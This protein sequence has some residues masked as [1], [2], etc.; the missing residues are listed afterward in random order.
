MAELLGIHLGELAA[1]FTFCNLYLHSETAHRQLFG[2]KFSLRT[3]TQPNDFC[4]QVLGFLKEACKDA[5]EWQEYSRKFRNRTESGLKRGLCI[6]KCEL[7]P[8]KD[9]S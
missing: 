3:L 1:S 8:H 2:E 7:L 9:F 4:D 5:V 6:R